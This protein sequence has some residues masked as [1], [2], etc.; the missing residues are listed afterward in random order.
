MPT[1]LIA[2]RILEKEIVHSLPPDANEDR[3]DRLS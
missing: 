2:Y 3:S 1:I